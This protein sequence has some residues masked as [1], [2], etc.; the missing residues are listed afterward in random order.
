MTSGI[1]RN[2]FTC[3]I[4][5]KPIDLDVI[6]ILNLDFTSLASLIRKYKNRFIKETSVFKTLTQ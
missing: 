6:K 3:S 2:E 4:L 5:P 1:F